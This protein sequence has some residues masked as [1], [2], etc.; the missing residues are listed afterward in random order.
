M[1]Q[2]S[3]SHWVDTERYYCV[4][5]EGHTGRH[6]DV[7]GREWT[8][9][10]V[11]GRGG[12][13]DMSEREDML[14]V[15]EEV[16]AIKTLWEPRERILEAMRRWGEKRANEGYRQGY[17]DGQENPDGVPVWRDSDADPE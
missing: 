13:R 10:A 11:P 16:D 9:D 17:V 5:D 15:I 7:S 2:C 3:S 6:R 1:P 4:R 8:L 14:A 12:E